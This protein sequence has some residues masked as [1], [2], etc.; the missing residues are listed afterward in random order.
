MKVRSS[1]SRWLCETDG[2]GPRCERPVQRTQLPAVRIHPQ[3]GRQVSTSLC[4]A[5]LR[6]A[7]FKTWISCQ[8]D[9]QVFAARLFT[10][11]WR[12]RSKG[13]VPF[14][15]VCRFCPAPVWT[16]ACSPAKWVELVFP[17][18]PAADPSSCRNNAAHTDVPPSS[19]TTRRFRCE[20]G[21]IHSSS[22]L[23]Y[24]LFVTIAHQ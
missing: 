16:H 23:S 8:A 3:I 20:N 14:E 18:A 11:S 12:R 6:C 17:M 10:S 22:F 9:A 7:A 24:F 4:E 21:C 1:S 5:A 15:I 2:A 19:V 13:C